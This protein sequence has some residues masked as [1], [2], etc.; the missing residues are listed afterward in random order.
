MDPIDIDIMEENMPTDAMIRECMSIWAEYG[1]DDAPETRIL[2][3]DI[4]NEVRDDLSTLRK[5]RRFSR[6]WANL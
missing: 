5:W 4:R 6:E 3:D 1:S 2:W